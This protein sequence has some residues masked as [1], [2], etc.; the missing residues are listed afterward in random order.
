MAQTSSRPLA[1]STP[2]VEPHVRP[3][4]SGITCRSAYGFGRSLTGGMFGLLKPLCAAAGAANASSGSSATITFFC[5]IENSR[6]AVV[7]VEP[8]LGAADAAAARGAVAHELLHAL[9]RVDL[10]R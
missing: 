6:S 8:D 5:V 10:A 3:S 1:A 4:G 9:P 2:A 7:A